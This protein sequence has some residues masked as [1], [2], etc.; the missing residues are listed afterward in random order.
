MTTYEPN[1]NV[2]SRG[3]GRT[4][5][6]VLDAVRIASKE[7]CRVVFVYTGCSPHY[8][9]D[10]IA[11]VLRPI[12]GFAERVDRRTFRVGESSICLVSDRHLE[13]DHNILLGGDV[14][15]FVDHAAEPPDFFSEWLATY[16]K[17]RK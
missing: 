17:T 13:R 16:S 4:Y 10:M 6:Q 12:K 1:Y 15:F 14:K 9:V 2:S 7:K 11:D 8:F 3:G 5:R